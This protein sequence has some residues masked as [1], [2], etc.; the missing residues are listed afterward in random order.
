MAKRAK[1]RAK[2]V[3][4]KL[5]KAYQALKGV[6]RAQE[7][8]TMD[9]K[10][11]VQLNLDELETLKEELGKAALTRVRFVALNAPFKRR[12]PILPT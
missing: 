12:S 4:P 10:G 9:A 8:G 5:K 1:R 3:S 2:R 11:N 6:I 7:V